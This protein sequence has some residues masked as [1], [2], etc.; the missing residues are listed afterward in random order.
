MPNWTKEQKQAIYKKGTNILVAAAAGSGKTAVL[1]ERIIN[2]VINEKIDIDKLLVVTFTNAAAAEMKERVLDALYKKIEEDPENKDLQRQITL[3]NMAQIC[4]IDSFCLDIVKNHFYELENISP[5]FRIA[6][7]TEIELLKQ[8]TLDEIFEEKYINEDENFTDLIKT[9]TN[10]RDD[11]PLKDLI[12]KIY[13]FISSN[14]SPL[15][16]LQEKV[17][18]FNLKDK[19]DEDFSQTIWGTILLNDVSEEVQDDMAMLKDV[20]SSLSYDVELED[21]KNAILSD[22]EQLKNLQ[23]NLNNWDNTYN[24]AQNFKFIDWPRKKVTSDIKDEAKAIRDQVRKKLYDKLNNTFV[25]DSKQS[26][27]DIYDMYKTLTKLKDLIIEFDKQFSKKKREKNILDFSD[28]EHFALSILVK[29]DEQGNLV[30]TEVAEKYT[31][32]FEEIAID[33]YQDSNLVQETILTSVSRGNNLF[34]VG[35][36]KQSIYKFRQAMPKLFLSKY[37]EYEIADDEAEKLETIQDMKKGK[38]IQLFKNF[39][40]R[41]NILDFTNL[42]FQNIMSEKIGE[43]EYNKNEYLNLGA[44]DYKETNQELK[45]EIDIIESTHN[46]DAEEIEISSDNDDEIQDLEKIEDIEIEAKYIAKKIKEL[47]Q[48]KYQI[49]DRKTESFRDIKY[50]DI[51]ILLRSTKEKANIYEQEMINLGIPVFSDSSEQYLETIE[52]QTILNLLK[53]I[54]NPIQDIPLVS[55]LRSNIGKF[56]DNELVE[57]RLSD[58]YDNFYNCMQKAVPNVNSKLKEK[59]NNFLENL[60]KWRKEKEYLALDELIWKI[61]IETGFYNYVGLMPNGELRQAN[62]K[63]LFEKARQYESASFKGLYNFIQFMEKLQLSSGDLG[64]AKIIGENDDVVRIMSIHKSKGLEF[65]VVFLANTNKQFN[66]QDIRKDSVLLHQDL[67]IGVK[68]I[69][70]DEQIQYDTLSREALKKQV[71]NENISEEMRILYVALT[72]AKEKLYITGIGKDIQEKIGKWESLNKIYPKENGK[73]NHLLIKKAKSYLDW[74]ILVYINA[75][76]SHSLKLEIKDKKEEMNKWNKLLN[77]VPESIQEETEFEH[78][79]N[80]YKTIQKELEYKYAFLAS[81]V[82]PTKIS[83][84]KIKELEQE[85]IQSLEEITSQQRSY[86]KNIEKSTEKL[87]ETASIKTSSEEEKSEFRKPEFLKENK[88]EK[89]TS[90][91]KGTITHLCLQK[92]DAKKEY[93]LEEIQNFIT[94]LQNTNI[95]TEK[96]AKSINPFKILEFTKSQ[97]GQDLKEA[98]EIYKEKPFYLNISAKEIYED[99]NLEE[100]ILVQGI[101]DLYYIDKNDNLILVDYKTDYVPEGKENELINKY[102]SQLS[103]YKTAL[104]EAL[105]RKVDKKY[106]YS[107]YLGKALE[108]KNK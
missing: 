6:E 96:E 5:N 26:N 76:E 9:Y 24:I 71:E 16:W 47:V 55:V 45:T 4:T 52:I 98:K 3:I 101:I 56:T 91:Q 36:V 13:N 100:N 85:K 25:S 73:I 69:N 42:V 79:K 86:T 63:M 29:K 54:D 68:Y 12:L 105:N 102:N 60:Q 80:L 65:P 94:E 37:N 78:R 33:E 28:I 41:G 87:K 44:T 18:M 46:E 66:M 19:L 58:K 64:T 103:L 88:D 84:T 2:K 57:I 20:V 92:L 74:V 39:R 61:Y 90:A 50:K 95:L 53:I 40:S 70:Y 34:M 30:K 23:N 14:P 108:I 82:I 106:I 51:V 107:I 27:Q 67:G 77:N 11:T 89:L 7:T 83:V 75:K 48:S 35:D 22:I 31:Q 8:G 43:I 38:K 104:E 99:Q 15:E 32:K 62:L 72:R 17:E 93:N 1:V 10:Y 81:T 59:I 97:I 21:F 49:Y